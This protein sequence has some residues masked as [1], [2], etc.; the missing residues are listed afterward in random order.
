MIKIKRIQSK[1]FAK[2]EGP[3]SVFIKS[4]EEAS[5]GIRFNYVFPILVDQ[6]LIGQIDGDLKVRLFSSQ[7]REPAISIKKSDVAG[8]NIIKKIDSQRYQNIESRKYTKRFFFEKFIDRPDFSLEK[9]EFEAQIVSAYLDDI[10]TAEI[11]Y[12]LSNGSTATIDTMEISHTKALKTYDIPD[13]HFYLTT[14]RNEKNKIQVAATTEDPVTSEFQFVVTSNSFTEMSSRDTLG[15]AV[16]PVNSSGV[17]AFEFEV[18][19]SDRTYSVRAIP[20]SR[21]FSQR[22]GNFQEIKSGFINDVKTIPFYVKSLTNESVDFSVFGINNTIKKVFLYRQKLLGG[23]REFV[24]SSNVFGSSTLLIQDLS[25]IPQYDYVYSIEYVDS[26]GTSHASPSEIVVPGLKLDKLAIVKSSLVESSQDSGFATF[27]VSVD[28]KTESLY[29]NLIGDIKS[30]GLESLLS[31]DLEKMTNNLKPITRVITTRISLATGIEQEIGVFPTGSI[32]ISDDSISGYIYRFEAAVRSTPESLESLA[33]GREILAN[34]AFN[35]G[36]SVDL[37]TKLIGNRQKESTSFS[38]KFFTRSSLRTSTIRSGNSLSLSDIGYYSGRTGVFSDVRINTE[39]Q[40]SVSL[41]NL[42]L[43]IT[44]RGN[45][46][47]WNAAGNTEEIDYFEITA[48][49]EV[50]KSTPTGLSRQVYFL[51]IQRP[52]SVSIIPVFYSGNRGNI[53]LARRF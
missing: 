34:N 51:G 50:F 25:R 22:I 12:V 14:T 28:Y 52:I 53:S 11:A 15:S 13:N 37:T 36:T 5:P 7:K 29:D 35:L 4:H 21:F 33:S 1:L 48:D 27:D 16:S 8:S 41:S 26:Q 20:V 39:S 6:S 47:S 32:T 19:N 49:Q 23:D 44:R 31:N 42:G 3:T 10:F 18:D 17:A 2:F 45:F 24:G 46:I 30:L 9:I 40:E 38:S 43:S